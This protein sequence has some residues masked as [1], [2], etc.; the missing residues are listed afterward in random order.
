M[1]VIL[2]DITG[3]PFDLTKNPLFIDHYNN[4]KVVLK[5]ASNTIFSY[6]P[7]INNNLLFIE[8]MHFENLHI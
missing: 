4:T 5:Y 7:S 2:N 8:N 1:S 3:K 6:T